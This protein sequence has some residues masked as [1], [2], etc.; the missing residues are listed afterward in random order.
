MQFRDTNEVKTFR[1]IRVIKNE[2]ILT[3]IYLTEQSS[4]WYC[5]VHKINHNALSL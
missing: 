5:G 3:P 4:T 2:K 1:N